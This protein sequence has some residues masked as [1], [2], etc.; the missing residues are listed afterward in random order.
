HNN[1]TGLIIG[2]HYGNKEVVRWFLSNRADVNAETDLGWRAIHFAAKRGHVATIDMLCSN[3]AVVDPVTS[4]H[5]TPL[6]LAL[7]SHMRDTV[8]KLINLGATLK[9]FDEGFICQYVHRGIL[10]PELLPRMRSSHP[11]SPTT[12]PRL[13][14][15]N[16]G[17]PT[18]STV[19]NNI[20]NSSEE[21]S[22]V[23]ASSYESAVTSSH[24]L[25]NQLQC[26]SSSYDLELARRKR[27]LAR[28]LPSIPGLSQNS[29]GI[30]VQQTQRLARADLPV[31]DRLDA[32]SQVVSA[33]PIKN[34]LGSVSHDGVHFTGLSIGSTNEPYLRLFEACMCE[35][36]CPTPLAIQLSH[37]SVLMA[38]LG[39]HKSASNTMM[40][41]GQ[42]PM[43]STTSYVC[44]LLRKLISKNNPQYRTG[45]LAHLS[46][47]LSHNSS[48]LA[49]HDC[50]TNV[51]PDLANFAPTILSTLVRLG[52]SLDQ[53]INVTR[54]TSFVGLI[55]RRL[56]DATS[57]DVFELCSARF[58]DLADILVGW[59][60]DP[61]SI[62]RGIKLDTIHRELCFGL[63]N[64]WL[65]PPIASST[66]A[67]PACIV[68]DKSNPLLI[69]S[70]RQMLCHLL[71][72]SESAMNTAISECPT[73]H[74]RTIQVVPT[75]VKPL[76]DPTAS[77][78]SVRLFLSVLAGIAQGVLVRLI[79]GG[80]NASLGHVLRLSLQE[81]CEW[82]ERLLQLL[83][84]AHACLRSWPHNQIVMWHPSHVASASA[85]HVSSSVIDGIENSVLC[86]LTCLIRSDEKVSVLLRQVTDYLKSRLLD[87][88]H[89][90]LTTETLRS[91]L[92][93]IILV[94][95]RFSNQVVALEYLRIY[96]GP[97]SLLHSY[98]TLFRS[99][100]DQE[101]PSC[102][103]LK[104][105]KYLVSFPNL[106]EEL[107]QL[108]FLDLEQAMQFFASNSEDRPSLAPSSWESLALFS[109]SLLSHL[110]RS[111]EK[112]FKTNIR[113]RLLS[114][115][116][117]DGVSVW[118]KL[119]VRVRIALLAIVTDQDVVAF[120]Q[121]AE[122][123]RRSSDFVG[124]Q[125]PSPLELE[126]IAHFVKVSI[127][128]C[129]SAEQ[130]CI[131]LSDLCT[132]AL[133]I[134][135]S[136]CPHTSSISTFLLCVRTLIAHSFVERSQIVSPCMVRLAEVAAA[137]GCTQI[138][139]AGMD[140]LLAISDSRLNAR[141]N[142]IPQPILSW[143]ISRRPDHSATA[144]VTPATKSHSNLTGLVVSVSAY[145]SLP[146]VAGVLG[147]LTRGAP[148][149]CTKHSSRLKL[150]H[151]P[152][153][154]IRRLTYLMSPLPA[155]MVSG[156]RLLP[157]LD[158]VKSVF[159]YAA[160]TMV[161]YKLKV[162]PWVSP[163][164]TFLALEGSLRA[165]LMRHQP[166]QRSTGGI[167][168][169]PP[170]NFETLSSDGLARQPWSRQLNQA[171]LL[172]MFLGFLE[173]NIANAT[174]GFALVLPRPV[175]PACAFFSANATTCSQWFTRVRG[176][177][178]RLTVDW[179]LVSVSEQSIGVESSAAVV[180]NTYKLL[181]SSVTAK[182]ANPWGSLAGL[183]DQ[184][185]VY[186]VRG[187]SNLVAWEELQALS[188]WTEQLAPTQ[189]YL[190]NPFGWLA[191]ATA[192]A[193]GHWDEA[194]RLLRGFLD[195]WFELKSSLS[196]I[197]YCALFNGRTETG[198][199][200]AIHLL[201]QC[202]LDVG[203]YDAAWNLRNTMGS[204]IDSQDVTPSQEVH[205]IRSSVRITWTRLDS[206][207]KLSSWSPSD[208][209][210]DV[211]GRNSSA[212]SSLT[213]W[214]GS[215]FADHLDTL[216]C[217][218]ASCFIRIKTGT[219]ES[220]AMD[221]YLSQLVTDARQAASAMALSFANDFATGSKCGISSGRS[222]CSWLS[223]ADVLLGSTIQ[224]LTDSELADC[225]LNTVS[226]CSWRH[227][228]GRR[229][230]VE[231]GRINSGLQACRWACAHESYSLAE[232]LLLREGQALSLLKNTNQDKV[233]LQMLY[234]LT[235]TATF[236]ETNR[237]SQIQRLRF[238]DCL[239]QL[240]WARSD[241]D[242]P[243][244]CYNN[245][246]AAID[247]LSRGLRTA[248]LE[249]VT[250]DSRQHAARCDISTEVALRLFEWLEKPALTGTQTWAEIIHQQASDQPLSAKVIKTTTTAHHLNF[251]SRLVDEPWAN[252]LPLVPSGE[253]TPAPK[254]N[255]SQQAGC[256]SWTS[257]L[258]MMATRLS[259]TGASTK[260]WLRMAEWCF[261]RGQ[262]LIEETRS[263]TRII[264]DSFADPKTPG[265]TSGSQK[266]PVMDMLEA[267]ECE[268][269]RIILRQRLNSS[270]QAEL[271]SPS[272]DL[273]L[274]HLLA[275]L[276]SFL[277][278][279]PVDDETAEDPP[280][281]KLRNVS[282][283]HLSK[284]C[285]D[286]NADDYHVARHLHDKLPSLFPS[287]GSLSAEVLR[288]LHHLVI[289]LTQRQ[290]SLYTS[291][292][293][294]YA[295]FLTVAGQNSVPELSVSKL[296]T[297]TATL[298]LLDFLSAPC[299]ALRNLV[300]GFLM[301]GGPATHSFDIHTPCTTD[302]ASATPRS[303]RAS[304]H[305]V[306]TFVPARIGTTLGGPAIW[307]ACLHHVLVRFSLPDPIAQNCLVAL[308]TR[309][310]LTEN[311]DHN[312]LLSPSLRFAAH[313]VFPAAVASL[314]A[315]NNRN[316]K[317]L[318]DKRM[319]SSRLVNAA[320]DVVHGSSLQPSPGS[321]CCFIQIIA[322]LKSAGFSEMVRQVETFV[323]ELQR[324]TLLWEELWLGCL[325]QHMDDL[326]KKVT[327]LESEIK[328]SLQFVDSGNTDS[329]GD[330][331]AMLQS[332][333]KENRAVPTPVL[334]PSSVVAGDMSS[335]GLRTATELLHLHKQKKSVDLLQNLLT[336]Q[337]LSV[338]QPTSDLLDQLCALTLDVQ[339]E[340]PHEEWFQRTFAPVVSELRE[341]LVNPTDL[342]D[343]KLPLV[344]MR[345]LIHQLHTVHHSPGASRLNP[346]AQPTGASR[347][348]G[349]DMLPLNKTS[350]SNTLSLS[351]YHLSPQLAQMQFSSF[352]TIPHIN[353]KQ[354]HNV[355]NSLANSSSIPLPGRFDLESASLSSRVAV[356]PTKT[357]PKRLLFRAQNGHTYPYLLKGLE[358]LRLDDRI[359][360]LF[361]LVNLAMTRRPTMDTE[362]FSQICARTY[363]VTPLGVRAGLLQMVQGAAP[364]FGLYKRWQI[365]TTK[366]DGDTVPSQSPSL[367]VSVP[368][369]GEL[370]H[371]RLKDL[372]LAANVPYQA[373]V[374]SSWPVET[375]K[376]VLTSLESE[377][378]PDLLSR[379]LWAAN[380]SC[381][382]WWRATRTFARS[383]GMMSSLGY[384]VGL[385]DRHLDN[386]LVDFTTGHLIHIDY[387]VCF[388]KGRTLRVAERVPFR[389]TQIIRHA[390][391]PVAQGNQCRGSFRVAAEET[392]SVAREILDPLLTQL[393][394]FLID[395]LIDWQ[396]KK[397]TTSML[398]TDFTHLGA[399]LGGGSWTTTKHQLATRTRKQRRIESECRLYSGLVA[400]RLLELGNTAYFGATIAALGQVITHL[401]V[402]QKWRASALL[403][404]AAEHSYRLLTNAS[405]TELEHAENRCTACEAVSQTLVDL[406][407]ELRDHV[408]AW[409]QCTSEHRELFR[410]LVDPTWLPSLLAA[411]GDL[412]SE[413]SLALTQY[414]A[415][416]R[417]YLSHPS[418]CPLNA[419]WTEL[420]RTL[421]STI[422]LFL[423]EPLSDAALESCLDT[424][425][426]HGCTRPP[427]SFDPILLRE[428]EKSVLE[429]RRLVAELSDN[430]AED[431]GPTVSINE[432]QS[433]IRPELENLHL[434]IYDQ[435]P[436]GV[437][438]YCW[439]LIDYLPGLIAN[440]FSLETDP[441]NW[442]CV[443]VS[444]H[445]QPTN[446][447]EQLSMFV[448]CLASLFSVLHH[449]PTGAFHFTA[450]YEA[451]ARRETAF[452]LGVRDVCHCLV[453]LKLN[454]IRLLLPAATDA[455]IDV[456]GD[457]AEDFS[458]F[459]ARHLT[460]SNPT[461]LPDLV[462]TY[463][464][465]YNLSENPSASRLHQVLIAVH[466]A[467]VNTAAQLDDI[468]Q[469]IRTC[470]VTALAWYYVDILAQATST[471]LSRCS[472]WREGAT[473][474]WGWESSGTCNSQAGSN[475][476][477]WLDEIYASGLMAFISILDDCR[478]H[479]QAIQTGSADVQQDILLTPFSATVDRFLGRLSSRIALA[480]LVSLAAGRLFCALIE[481][482]GISV[483]RLVN[484]KVVGVPDVLFTPS[485]EKLVEAAGLQLSVSHPIG[486]QHLRG[487]ASNL[488]YR[489]VNRA[490]RANERASKALKL[491]LADK[492]LAHLSRSL[493]AF[494]WI[495][496]PQYNANDTAQLNLDSKPQPL[497][498][499]TLRDALTTIET[500]IA[501][502]E[503][504]STDRSKSKTFRLIDVAR[505]VQ[506]FEQLRITGPSSCS[507][508][509]VCMQLL[510]QLRE[511]L[512]A[513][514]RVSDQLTEL[515][516]I[517]LSLKKKYNLQ[518]PAQAWLSTNCTTESSG[519]CTLKEQMA[520]D[521]ST[522]KITLKHALK[523]LNNT[524]HELR[525]PNTQSVT[526]PNNAI[527]EKTLVTATSRTAG[528]VGRQ[529]QKNNV[530]QPTSF[531]LI[532]SGSLPATK[533]STLVNTLRVTLTM[534]QCERLSDIRQLVKMLSRYELA[535]VHLLSENDQ[536]PEITETLSSWSSWLESHQ[537]WTHNAS[538]LLKKLSKFVTQ[539]DTNRIL[540]TLD[541]RRLNA[542]QL[543]ELAAEADQAASIL[544]DC[545]LVARQVWSE[546]IQ[547]LFVAIR[548][549]VKSDPRLSH[550]IETCFEGLENRFVSLLDLLKSEPSSD[551]LAETP[552]KESSARDTKTQLKLEPFEKALNPYALN[553]WRRVRSRISGCD[554]MLTPHRGATR[555]QALL[556]A[557]DTDLTVTSLSVAEQ[558][559]LCISA[560]TDVE[561]LAL[562]YEG[563]TAWNYQRF[564]QYTRVSVVVPATSVAQYAQAMRSTKFCCYHSRHFT[565]TIIHHP[566]E[567]IRKHRHEMLEFQAVL[568][569][570]AI[571]NEAQITPSVDDYSGCMVL[572]EP[573]QLTVL[574]VFRDRN[575]CCTA[576]HL[577]SNWF[578]TNLPMPEN[579]SNDSE[580]S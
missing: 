552:R 348:L 27:E 489:L 373:Q 344:L 162:A 239:A 496:T 510:R 574:G 204:L 98:K 534:L 508:Y 91:L 473:C 85:L 42:T 365:R 435:G 83:K 14:L 568:F 312:R 548:R 134:L 352:G 148:H 322:A 223:Q 355:G 273:H 195:K 539:L 101:P 384:L 361:E 8:R 380:M 579:T 465:N 398:I 254:T 430:V 580:N 122:L 65:E 471:M 181:S 362:Q 480:S 444:A 24:A 188:D 72:D 205:S 1:V 36:H 193:R 542:S 144:L 225:C 543:R 271:E 319:C 234:S 370:F 115:L 372:L 560:A 60:V 423:E 191:G 67:S 282:E 561:N 104:T 475:P 512:T 429:T 266:Y 520:L 364:L 345:Q 212:Y 449:Q 187:L 93:L 231:W 351:L 32:L 371:A 199:S 407:Q 354:E 293:Q 20:I 33:L 333:D 23:V 488:I 129:K 124:V 493:A 414:H 121:S 469:R 570:Y 337:Y 564:C 526:A 336:T 161:D 37:L 387:N 138:S 109:L 388:D 100:P 261:G 445:D 160:W 300:A 546:L 346:R 439:A 405:S 353:S 270:T 381:A 288:S 131:L 216:L 329:P 203:D 318:D 127:E 477:S 303:G 421:Q 246:L 578:V 2:A 133:K 324:I 383:A 152:Y 250:Q 19:S 448:E 311:V 249:E 524:R 157:R 259:P 357:R 316:S 173:R 289:V 200:Y 434:F 294:A 575:I 547:P 466:L 525:V 71:E 21:R 16:Q 295:T 172:V 56:V 64:W 63:A 458:K 506:F 241:S 140:L 229:C 176:L 226:D 147:I 50:A 146:A 145:P 74:S 500:A 467:L 230:G 509:Y 128:Q 180:Y 457:L 549:T 169:V 206:L 558:V 221:G 447:L 341:S 105:M 52:E 51:L 511:A 108:T 268:A 215:A 245:K 490:T 240:L 513:Q 573:P 403:C 177:V 286:E 455:L 120:I 417:V 18:L 47:M 556:D 492:H 523:Q 156:R 96:F 30:I 399:Y 385:G 379:E 11:D 437:T 211:T 189:G 562:M 252:G 565:T 308:L 222:L 515:D 136:Q 237:L 522:A 89:L 377:T 192:L 470:S 418:L 264:L 531:S 159:W 201:L 54:L 571:V 557:E 459:V 292:A 296:D 452:L 7:H 278:L 338:T 255:S 540:S 126:L 291:A 422:G 521:V 262:S 491:E 175:S 537:A 502:Y 577:L 258:L 112:A 335:N 10:P 123:L 202:Y 304:A 310:L 25:M 73:L 46:R 228:V 179:P 76:S 31:N 297:T 553:V 527:M 3:G 272:V 530:G 566:E 94:T 481:D 424:F 79:A 77:L 142:G 386:L 43:S 137:H 436:V 325:S 391:G 366:L 479:W 563:W 472:E 44:R 107:S 461:S 207:K 438:S 550:A 456:T 376:E 394:A 408:N 165:F 431:A 330:S 567:S 321:E 263:A 516:R 505:S 397:S 503:S 486:V 154:W 178:A 163:L 171:Q 116:E 269:A 358:D 419:C 12:K 151:S 476:C 514:K 218:S 529:S 69:K 247:V 331:D 260:A 284:I 485:A 168:K 190:F 519:V 375:L 356:L 396:T 39:N 84:S 464:G 495:H 132:L 416:A 569:T 446:Y 342:N 196:F 460:E 78:T 484:S 285:P 576:E 497:F 158:A 82:G 220:H 277:V 265:N 213:W 313:L 99:G 183:S 185:L 238:S 170:P 499:L 233:N 463:L 57:D 334:S 143:F 275:A 306:G 328:R 34:L 406:Q 389:L 92:R 390:L 110:L 426:D 125:T 395:P 359:M 208:F 478:A 343:A 535:S 117:H 227:L 40:D 347:R 184:L 217:S 166:E 392:L 538:Q 367:T 420:V 536:P 235:R 280:G 248:L 244:E 360:R 349:V 402:W 62:P 59:G 551:N 323:S 209:S 315:H 404:T 242:D 309:L 174:E 317:F 29:S 4:E 219:M 544:A 106:V 427:D 224:Q 55:G 528:P 210:Q 555:S 49:T 186:T 214:S 518:W 118:N 28:R 374:R 267:E 432:L 545:N 393:K 453:G 339:P 410:E 443:D 22:F 494:R 90:S 332:S 41:G 483:R 81:R 442:S 440:L 53:P 153:D 541:R 314:D 350:L 290:Y 68:P 301:N 369:P 287:S 251:F 135:D 276:A 517:L 26:Q 501:N 15:Y 66:V 487:P 257:R 482:T 75:D 326:T 130:R 141:F 305:R 114:G 6:S 454:L 378:P 236:C 320:A 283:F 38:A 86:L 113:L 411:Q 409:E 61:S 150:L 119:P 149:S 298:K 103:I 97:R 468:A 533:H 413:L 13:Q 462:G 155:D 139:E 340:T 415:V 433:V 281:N 194:V 58:S 274:P 554:P 507:A 232:R 45:I 9:Q 35:S 48:N 425:S 279:E 88:T 559:D 572:V 70:I 363:A 198:V 95:T 451:D 302:T 5:E 450:G 102:M 382:A 182:D 441:Q 412:C 400:T 307:E 474:L 243:V 401:S 504:V 498:P 368:R 17:A 80:V 164:K 428:L 532:D 253:L 197:D 111:T 256:T 167:V 299:R 327:L 87:F